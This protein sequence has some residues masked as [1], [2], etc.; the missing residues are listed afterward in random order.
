MDEMKPKQ[1]WGQNEEAKNGPVFRKETWQK[2]L[3]SSLLQSR[4]ST[5][6]HKDE[7]TF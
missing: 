7:A 3:T 1:T 2:I 6:K 5:C 4:F